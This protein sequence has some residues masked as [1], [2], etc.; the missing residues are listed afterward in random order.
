MNCYHHTEK[1]AVGSCKHCY[2]G[3]CFDCATDTGNG[4]A[5]HDHVEAVNAVNQVIDKN[6]KAVKDAPINLFIG[7]IF[8]ML[9]GVGFVAAGLLIAQKTQPFLLFLG[10]G[11]IL[12]AL[13][14]IIRSRKIFKK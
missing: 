13:V 8:N 9:M 7:P 10:S 5:C 1:S 11:F 3:L 6:I 12:F 14:E 4:L 2:K